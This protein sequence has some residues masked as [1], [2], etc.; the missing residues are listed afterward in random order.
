MMKKAVK[1][2]L[3]NLFFWQTRKNIVYV[4]IDQSLI[5]N[6]PDHLERCKFYLNDSYKLIIYKNEFDFFLNLLRHGPY[7]ALFTSEN[8]FNPIKSLYFLN[9][10]YHTN[11]SDGWAWHEALSKLKPIR[12]KE[13]EESKN[14]L[15]QYY[16]SLPKIRVQ[17]YYGYRAKFSKIQKIG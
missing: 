1:F 17:P 10:D 2:L 14:R 4:F 8:I 15:V 3:R 6:Y 13:I 12:K 9:V 7:R 16:N 11:P 5:T